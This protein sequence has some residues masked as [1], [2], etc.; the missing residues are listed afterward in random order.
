MTSIT[1][2]QKFFIISQN[3]KIIDRFIKT[4]NNYIIDQLKTKFAIH[5]R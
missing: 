3:I 4:L 1:K 2:I 5:K